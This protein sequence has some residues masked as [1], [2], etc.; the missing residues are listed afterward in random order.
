MIK[1]YLDIGGENMSKGND[2]REEHVKI[3]KEIKNPTIRQVLSL[4]DKLN[5]DIKVLAKYFIDKTYLDI[6][7]ENKK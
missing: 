6:E 5:I 4:S 2:L 1:F 7:E 3:L